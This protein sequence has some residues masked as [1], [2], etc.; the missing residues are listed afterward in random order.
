GVDVDQKLTNGARYRDKRP[1]AQKMWSTMM[2]TL[3][4][5]GALREEHGVEYVY[6]H[7]KRIAVETLNDPKPKKRRPFKASFVRLPNFWIERLR[8]ARRVSTVVLALVIL[9]EA[10][11]RQ[12]LGGEIVLS[13]EVTGMSRD[14][15]CRATKELNRRHGNARELQRGSVAG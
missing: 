14:V 11:K 2:R 15:K 3:Q 4:E 8:R 12:H 5:I 9:R 10:F 1:V 7:G 13:T 6:R